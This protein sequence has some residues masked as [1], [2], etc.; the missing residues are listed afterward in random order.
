MKSSRHCKR[1]PGAATSQRACDECLERLGNAAEAGGLP[2]LKDLCLLLQQWLGSAAQAGAVSDEGRR[3]L[4]HFGTLA[5]AYARRPSDRE[6]VSALIAMLRKPPLA[7]VQ[8]EEDAVCLA[9]MLL[10]DS[11]PLGELVLDGAADGGFAE[12]SCSRRV[13]AR[14]ALAGESRPGFDD[15]DVR[16]RGVGAAR[17]DR[18][19]T[20]DAQ[21]LVVE[22]EPA[23]PKVWAEAA[24]D[25]VGDLSD[26]LE[27][28]AARLQ[29]TAVEQPASAA[30]ASPASTGRRA[31]ARGN[32]PPACGAGID[33]RHDRR[34]TRGG[35]GAR[36]FRRAFTGE[37]CRCRCREGGLRTRGSGH[38]A[39]RRCVGNGGFQGT[40]AG[41][42]PSSESTCMRFR[43]AGWP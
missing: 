5:E 19:R 1:P 35:Y 28:A 31:G 34:V 6:A 42:H 32:A 20:S 39:L 37:R 14:S 18:V 17:G 27:A 40:G 9:D 26:A 4:E 3:A 15:A 16:P 41:L 21:E 2:G 43:F 36:H 24:F 13:Q 29:E 8:S 12:F 23:S 11:S 38:R 25:R 7:V 33:R 10:A 22:T 30:D